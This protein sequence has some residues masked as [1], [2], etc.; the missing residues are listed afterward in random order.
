MI[1]TLSFGRVMNIIGCSLKDFEENPDNDFEIDE[2]EAVRLINSKYINVTSLKI[3]LEQNIL[4]SERE[5]YYS[6]GEIIKLSNVLD[7]ITNHFISMT[8]TYQTIRMTE[9]EISWSSK[10]RKKFIDFCEQTNGLMNPYIFDFFYVYKN[11]NPLVFFFKNEVNA[12]MDTYVSVKK[13]V[14]L[15]GV[16]RNYF[17]SNKYNIIEF[18]KVADSQFIL[19]IEMEELYKR[20]KETYSPVT[21]SKALNI[22]KTNYHN[23][24]KEYSIENEKGFVH[25]SVI[26]FLK[27]EQQQLLI[28]LDENYISYAEMKDTL[29]KFGRKNA[30][31]ARDSITNSKEIPPLAKILGGKWNGATLVLYSRK[32]FLEYL[33]SVK[34]EE[35]LKT[36]TNN[37]A[38]TL[39][40]EC[41]KISEL[42]FND[43][44]NSTEE[45]LL[46]HIK[47]RLTSTE[48][49]YKS[50][51]ALIRE[52]ITMT[53]LLIELTQLKEIFDYKEAELDLLIFNRQDLTKSTKEYFY[54]FIYRI[55]ESKGEYGGYWS[56]KKV[57][58][59]F[60]A[61]RENKNKDVYS[62]DEFLA[63]SD[64]CNE[65]EPHLKKAMD[66]V[67]PADYFSYWL[68]VLIHLNNGWRKADVLRTPRIDLKGVSCQG[69]D[70]KWFLD[71]KLSEKDVDVVIAKMASK[72]LYHSKTGKRRHFFY[73][74]SLKHTIATVIC[75]CEVI[76]QVNNPLSATL[77]SSPAISKKQSLLNSFYGEFKLT[78]F[79][80]GSLKMNRTVLTLMYEIAESN[81]GS[82]SGILVSKTMRNHTSLE[83]T[84]I[85]INITQEQVN[86]LSRKLFNLGSFGYTYELLSDLLESP[87]NDQKKDYNVLTIKETVGDTYKVERLSE[88][89]LYLIQNRFESSV[90]KEYL[91]SLSS[92]ELVNLKRDIDYGNNVAK[93][94]NVSCL[95]KECQYPEKNCYKCHFAIYHMLGLSALGERFKTKVREFKKA[96]EDATTKGTKTKLTNDLYRDLYLMQLAKKK[97]GGE[98][99]DEFIIDAQYDSLLVELKSIGS[100]KEYYTLRD[101]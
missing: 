4:S 75:I 11:A 77:I 54:S 53:K 82:T 16:N 52:F 6:Q 89:F 92:N 91:Q 30:S 81:D 37:N 85:Y 65:F 32:E 1:K 97:F 22:S 62:V 76:Q 88:D 27:E 99:I 34:T 59:P 60:N 33:K 61:P 78:D 36:V 66:Y 23:V 3:L 26:D 63:L 55:N 45:L 19:K 41:L 93:E 14:E 44:G 12:F 84:N 74:E 56:L 21:G 94:S 95:F 10:T 51:R 24:L 47:V 5:H 100:V 86:L 18:A 58:N 79:N 80:F 8:E 43:Y 31:V 35:L 29:S 57:K 46:N 15:C 28:D 98:V 69:E 87:L 68:Y 48:A 7:F 20:L 13:A 50:L 67:E 73:D 90:V 2:E 25:A 38:Y 40:L 49:G 17:T 72:E 70:F 96:F 64:Y 39:F 83:M 9:L 71:H 42:E 101:V